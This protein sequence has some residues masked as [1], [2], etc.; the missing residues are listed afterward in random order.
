MEV[1]RKQQE[2]KFGRLRTNQRK[3]LLL[4]KGCPE[5]RK[6]IKKTAGPKSPMAN[7]T[8]KATR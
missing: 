3:V 6:W 2:I 1:M 8:L 4:K 7:A 5:K